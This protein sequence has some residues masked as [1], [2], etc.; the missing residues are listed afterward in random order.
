MY[1]LQSIIC[2]LWE[3]ETIWVTSRNTITGAMFELWSVN[4]FNLNKSYSCSKI[5][6]RYNFLWQIV[7]FLTL[8]LS[9]PS[10]SLV[11]VSDS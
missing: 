7:P 11:K 3:K 8:F 2:I 6:R 10:G 9:R 1:P 4:A 5:K